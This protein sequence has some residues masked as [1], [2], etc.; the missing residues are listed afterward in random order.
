MTTIA[1]LAQTLQEVLT[2]TADARARTIST[3]T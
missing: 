2:T 3:A 1:D